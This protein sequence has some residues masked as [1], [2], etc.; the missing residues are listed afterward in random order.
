MIKSERLLKVITMAINSITKCTICGKE[1]H[2]SEYD[3]HRKEHKDKYV[4]REKEE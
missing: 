3:K 2:P 1:M 4:K